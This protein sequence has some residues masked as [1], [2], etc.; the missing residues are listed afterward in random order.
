MFAG[1]WLVHAAP[2]EAAQLQD[3]APRCLGVGKANA[4]A[5]LAALLAVEPRPAGVLLFGVAGAVPPRLRDGAAAF[6]I[7]DVVV[8]TA[9]RFAD[10]GIET[11]D[12]WLDLAD[13]GLADTGP[14]AAALDIAAATGLPVVDA[15]TV[16]TCSGNDERAAA[17]WE[18]CG[19]ALESM[20]GA[21]VAM[22]CAKFGVPWLQVRAISNWT[23]DREAG[24]WDLARAVAAVQQHVRALV[25]ADR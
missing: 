16:S 10:E 3:L 25:A 21:A 17:L 20:E 14:F 13:L 22:V 5:S 24:E 23:G 7:G 19:T 18:R 12:G 11:P 8:V 4:A 15:C 1:W 9:D 6:G 2:V